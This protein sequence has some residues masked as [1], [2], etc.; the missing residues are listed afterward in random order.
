MECQLSGPPVLSLPEEGCPAGV[1]PPRLP[2][3]PPSCPNVA[4]FRFKKMPHGPWMAPGSPLVLT[5]TPRTG[6]CKLYCNGDMLLTVIQ[7]STREAE[8]TGSCVPECSGSLDC[9]R[10][11]LAQRVAANSSALNLSC[12]HSLP[13]ES[14]VSLTRFPYHG[15]QV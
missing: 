5:V 12:S 15:I 1:V 11:G 10:T 7:P 2:W 3:A 9:S 14:P 13:P 4:V 6:P 8:V